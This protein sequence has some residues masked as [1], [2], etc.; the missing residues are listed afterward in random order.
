MNS[1]L[2]QFYGQHGSPSLNYVGPCVVCGSGMGCLSGI[3]L[4]ISRLFPQQM[5]LG[6]ESEYSPYL[7]LHYKAMPDSALFGDQ[8]TFCIKEYTVN[9]FGFSSHKVFVPTT[10]EL[11][12]CDMKAAPETVIADGCPCVSATDGRIVGLR[13]HRLLIPSL[14]LAASRSGVLTAG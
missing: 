2:S 7:A 9:T 5:F 11:C 14:Y 6:A 1:Y 8:P 4:Y 3:P 12:C 10:T 13:G